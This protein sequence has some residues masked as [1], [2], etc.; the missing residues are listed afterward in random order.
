MDSARDKTL[1]TEDGLQ[2]YDIAT[3]LKLRKSWSDQ[4]LDGRLHGSS[5][6]AALN[7]MEKGEAEV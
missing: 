5:M 3:L 1:T 4:G 6:R 7:S 2:A